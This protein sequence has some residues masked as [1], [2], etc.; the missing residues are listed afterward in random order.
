MEKQLQRSEKQEVTSSAEQ[1]RTGPVFTPAVDI[2]ENESALTVLAD[3]PG[4][5]AKNLKIDLRENILTLTALVDSPQG[6]KETDVFREYECGTFFR[7]FT[8]AET[9][10]QTKIE[11]ELH[12]GVL[13]LQ[14]PKTEA[15]RPRQI[16]VKA[17]S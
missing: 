6:E 4:V 16:A 8:L 10:D 12:D 13:R 15:A 11:A 9:I 1:T 2:F 14:L 7:Q 3:L 17:S 5:T